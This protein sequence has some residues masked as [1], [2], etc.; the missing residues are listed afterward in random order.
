MEYP[1]Q[2]G[3]GTYSLLPGLLYLGQV[4]PWSWGAQ[5]LSTVRIGHNEHDYRL[6]D[7]VDMRLWLARELTPLV[8][9]SV[10]AGGES[11]SNIR[12][13]DLS[14]DP[15]DEPTRD[16]TRQGGTR[17]NTPIGVVIH[18]QHGVFKGQQLLIEADVPYLQSLTGPQLKRNYMLHAA[19][20]WAF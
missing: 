13:A 16:P 1:M 12:G 8:S 3:S 15:L 20:Q 19:W 14:L 7:R 5:V 18:P 17:L 2:S 10:A 9:V 6:G 4:M 11:W